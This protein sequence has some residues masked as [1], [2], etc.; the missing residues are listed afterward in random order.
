VSCSSLQAPV[1]LVTER[2]GG[3]GVP[4]SKRC[5]TVPQW[6]KKAPRA[7]L[8]MSLSHSTPAGRPLRA[9]AS[10][11][12]AFMP[13]WICRIIPFMLVICPKVGVVLPL[14]TVVALVLAP[15]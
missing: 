10:Q 14:T 7:Q 6:R 13:N 5:T 8:Q 3:S 11:N 1:A 15:C 12:I 2:L 4:I 9:R